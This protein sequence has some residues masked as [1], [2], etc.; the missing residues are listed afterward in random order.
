MPDAS[1]NLTVT[2]LSHFVAVAASPSTSP[3]TSPV[4]APVSGPANFAAV[5]VPSAPVPVSVI[6]LVVV[7]APDIDPP[8][9]P[10]YVV[11]NRVS[12]S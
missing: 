7:S 4:T 1:P 5:T 8:A 12:F 10:R 6:L 3:V 9:L 11:L 2:G